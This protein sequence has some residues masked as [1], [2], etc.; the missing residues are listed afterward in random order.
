MAWSWASWFIL[1]LELCVRA[2]RLKAE[3]PLKD[4]TVTSNRWY[5]ASD[6]S[7]SY[8]AGDLEYLQKTV[9]LLVLCEIILIK[10]KAG[11]K[12]VSFELFIG[13]VLKMSAVQKI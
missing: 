13:T 11:K 9:L 7:I 10:K 2:S 3:E 6:E 5:M 8:R 12:F 4:I 1:C